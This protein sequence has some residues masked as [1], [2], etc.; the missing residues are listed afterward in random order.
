MM[1][2]GNIAAGHAPN[3]LLAAET[4]TISYVC[5]DGTTVAVKIGELLLHTSRYTTRNL[6]VGKTF[7]AKR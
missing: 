7:N 5:N 4:G 6:Y 2:D 3:S 1:S